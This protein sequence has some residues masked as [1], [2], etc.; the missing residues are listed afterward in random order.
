M[1]HDLLEY[2]NILSHNVWSEQHFE[3]IANYALCF[4]ASYSHIQGDCI[5]SVQR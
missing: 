5:Q 2:E 1:N 4:Q 3:W